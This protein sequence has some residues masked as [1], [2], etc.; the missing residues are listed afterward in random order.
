MAAV[1][2]NGLAIACHTRAKARPRMRT[3]LAVSILIH[4]FFCWYRRLRPGLLACVRGQALCH[5]W[6]TGAA[7]GG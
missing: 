1:E 3:A 5:P 2:H 7:A 4:P 6:V